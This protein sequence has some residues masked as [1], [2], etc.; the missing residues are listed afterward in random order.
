MA[1]RHVYTALL[2]CLHVIKALIGNWGIYLLPKTEFFLMPIGW[3]VKTGRAL[4]L[5]I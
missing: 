4:S 1:E 3:G 2:L 5:T